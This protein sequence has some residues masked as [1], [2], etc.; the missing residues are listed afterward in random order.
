MMWVSILINYPNVCSNVERAKTYYSLIH[1][2]HVNSQNFFD[3]LPYKGNYWVLV[4]SIEKWYM[5][6]V[7][8]Y[9]H[10]VNIENWRGTKHPEKPLGFNSIKC[11][12]LS[13][14]FSS[15]VFIP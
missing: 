3:S 10:W 9:K 2:L 15:I 6:Y 8:C 4:F 14:S 13:L 11:S 1:I 7:L 12:Q 5:K